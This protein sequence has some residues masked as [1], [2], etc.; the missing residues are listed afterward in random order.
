M[1]TDS[2]RSRPTNHACR[3]R[4]QT[5]LL[6]APLLLVIVGISGCTNERT[7]E[8]TASPPEASLASMRT[9]PPPPSAYWRIPGAKGRGQPIYPEQIEE[10]MIEMAGK[11]ALQEVVLDRL[12]ARELAAQE[13]TIDAEAIARE[14]AVLLEALDDDADRATRLLR[15][16]RLKEGLGPNRY[17]ALLRRN[18]MLRALVAREV[19]ITEEAIRAVWDREHGPRRVARIVVV[20][21]L[22]DARVVSDRLAAG[23]RFAELAAR[24]SMDPS[25]STGGLVDPVARLDPSW[26]TSFRETL[27]SLEEGAASSP[28]LVDDAYVLV[29]HV[30][31]LPG[32]GSTPESGRE[33]AIEIL[34][35]SQERLLMDALARR[36]LDDVTIDVIDGALERA[37]R[38]TD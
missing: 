36:M 17:R 8:V 13:R 4:S 24:M 5:V 3:H 14:E 30:E 18:A 15:T 31:E 9:A 38:E 22:Q 23:E 33:E 26:P 19:S 10:V 2:T 20:E 29:Q 25:A 34:R 37:Y 32:D 7:G 35:R 16:V 21:N 27:W 6:L 11:R 12:L 28:I 1:V